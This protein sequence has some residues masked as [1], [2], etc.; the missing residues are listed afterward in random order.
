[1]CDGLA[2]H[3]EER[4]TYCGLLHTHK[5]HSEL[6]LFLVGLGMDPAKWQLSV[7][8][9][10]DLRNSGRQLVDQVLSS[11]EEQELHLQF[12]LL[13]FGGVFGQ[14]QVAVEAD[15]VAVLL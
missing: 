15:V 12:S 14:W 9:L 4:A 3:V 1:M 6:L 7:A 10:A 5:Y 8:P 11:D 13:L 2:G